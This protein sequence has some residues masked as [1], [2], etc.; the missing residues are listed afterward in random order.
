MYVWDTLRDVASFHK[1]SAYPGTDGNIVI[2]G[3]R[4]IYGSVFLHL[5][6][7]RRGDRITLYAG[8]LPYLYQVVE[9]V[10]LPYVHATPKQMADHLRLLGETREERLTLLTCTPVGTATHRLY[11]I[12]EPFP[13]ELEGPIRR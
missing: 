2:N 3:H 7:I 9:I 4:D 12:A 6:K 5:N 11:V 10:K 1:T 8:D 13:G